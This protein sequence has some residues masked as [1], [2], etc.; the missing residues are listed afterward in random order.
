[1]STPAADGLCG[2][3][4]EEL[5]AATTL[6][7]HFCCDKTTACHRLGA[8]HGGHFWWQTC[9]CGLGGLYRLKSNFTCQW[10]KAEHKPPAGL[11]FPFPVPSVTWTGL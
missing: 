8:W 7:C 2:R 6:G 3:V 1:M 11:R 9:H 10:I 4:L 5:H